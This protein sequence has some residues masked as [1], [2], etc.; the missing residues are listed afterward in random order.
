M[1]TSLKLVAVGVVFAIGAAAPLATLAQDKAKVFKDREALMKQQGADLG[2]VKGYLD[3]KARHDRRALQRALNS[4]VCD[5]VPFQ[6][7]S[8]A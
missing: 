8:D 6:E 2:A 3:D 5:L 4:Y 7:C 1:K